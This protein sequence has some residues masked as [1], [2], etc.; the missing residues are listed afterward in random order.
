MSLKARSVEQIWCS[1]FLLPQRNRPVVMKPRKKMS[2]SLEDSANNSSDPSLLDVLIQRLEDDKASASGSAALPTEAAAEMVPEDN[3][4]KDNEPQALYSE[5]ATPLFLALENSEWREALELLEQD[6]SQ[7]A[8]WV[9]ST[10]TQ[11]SPGDW[12]LWK[13]LP[14]HEA[15]RREAPAWMVSAVLSAHPTAV[16]QTTLFGELPLHVAVKCS[17]SP[18]VVNL[19]LVSYWPAIVAT[20]QTGR[21]PLQILHE[22]EVA[23]IR[24]QETVYESLVRAQ[25]TWSVLHHDHA[26]DMKS[27]HEQHQRT[28]QDIQ[29]QHH[30]EMRQKEEALEQ[31]QKYTDQLEERLKSS[32]QQESKL[33]AQ[34]DSMEEQGLVAK[35]HVK[36][37]QT[38]VLELAQ[39]K[40]NEAQT[41]QNMKLSITRHQIE[42]ETKDK[43]IKE[44]QTSLQLLT[45]FQ[46]SLVKQR[47]QDSREKA[48][49][50]MDS[51]DSLHSL[52]DE[53]RTNMG[54]LLGQL[55]IEALKLRQ[56]GKFEDE[57]KLDTDDDYDTQTY[58]E[59]DEDGSSEEDE[60]PNLAL[61]SAALAASSALKADNKNT[62]QTQ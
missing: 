46:E 55:G 58:G 35:E 52:L 36:D 38:R 22:A 16:C 3:V 5:G 24:E 6:P 1:S 45:A 27:Q 44:L 20:D 25:H 57:K 26:M 28:I 32:S 60:D 11:E 56:P 43:Q 18:A 49:S 9:V 59:D 48:K 30:R 51:F 41:V 21:T 53:N 19:L 47:L 42:Q 61:M 37:L 40:Q 39:A 15:C 54:A 2:G 17:A 34:L 50:M 12:N 62:G 7:A 4:D 10:G 33:H 23:D 29:R 14:L 13:R 31:I 8:T